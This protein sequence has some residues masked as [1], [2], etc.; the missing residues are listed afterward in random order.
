[1]KEV[2]QFVSGKLSVLDAVRGTATNFVLKKY[3]D[4]GTIL[5]DDKN[6]DE[7]MLVTP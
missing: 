4:H 6:T 2:A 1:M 5:D 3:K 7:R